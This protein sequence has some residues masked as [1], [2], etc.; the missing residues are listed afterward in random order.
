VTVSGSSL[1]VANI[2]FAA[3]T[4]KLTAPPTL[5]VS[6][7][8]N[9]SVGASFASNSGNVVFNGG[10]STQLLQAGGSSTFNNVTIAAGTSVELESNVTV[11]GV[12]TNLG[13]LILNRFNVLP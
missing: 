2:S 10:G 13:S 3:S 4:D 5:Y 7:N 11:V 8:W 6:G 9:D 12:F 1:Q